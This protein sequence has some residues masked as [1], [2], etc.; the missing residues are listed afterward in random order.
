MD[1]KNILIIEDSE[2]Y[3]NYFYELLKREGF[4]VLKAKNGAEGV[5]I[6]LREEPDLILL[7]VIMPV[8]DG[9]TALEKIRES[10]W[11]KKVPIIML[12]NLDDVQRVSEATSYNVRDYLVKSDVSTKD[13]LDKIKK[14]LKLE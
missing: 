10:N 12:T 1:K 4:N 3:L 8:M 14:E 13:V 9:M 5:E 6:A 11:E 2:T 7:D